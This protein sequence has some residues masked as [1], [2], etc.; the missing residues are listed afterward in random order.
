MNSGDFTVWHF[1]APLIQA[2]TS[3][4]EFIVWSDDAPLVQRAEPPD[5][6]TGYVYSGDFSIWDGEVPI[7]QVGAY[8]GD[9][10]SWLDSVPVVAFGS[11]PP[12]PPF[13]R[14]RVWIATYNSVTRA[15]SY[16][17]A[18]FTFEPASLAG[19]AV[20]PIVEIV[21]QFTFEDGSLAS[22]TAEEWY[23]P[24]ALQQFDFEDSDLST[25]VTA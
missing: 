13:N 1:G 4:G 16:V 3:S 25:W 9:F 22:W 6:S 10:A 19:W 20:G 7:L 12:G 23:A 5:P 11:L 21:D 2:G 8:S 15:T 17:F 14:R 18:R 24:F